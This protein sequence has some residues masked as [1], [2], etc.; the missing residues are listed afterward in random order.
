MR[1]LISAAQKRTL[2][3][4]FLFP[5]GKVHRWALG[6]RARAPAR[7][8]PGARKNSYIVWKAGEEKASFHFIFFALLCDISYAVDVSTNLIEPH[9]PPHLHIC[10]LKGVASTQRMR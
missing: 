3:C 10:T 2:V 4:L 9:D 5:P 6:N 8:A 1:T 7:T